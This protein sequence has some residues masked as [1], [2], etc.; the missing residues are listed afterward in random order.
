MHESPTFN[1][2]RLVTVVMLT[3]A[4]LNVQAEVSSPVGVI[5]GRQVTVTG[6]PE[7]EYVRTQ[8]RVSVTSLPTHNDL[9]N[10]L[11]SYWCYVWKIDDVE[12]ASE[13]GVGSATVIPVHPILQG[14][15][16]N[17]PSSA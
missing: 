15:Y 2:P 8:N 4:G 3:C 7:I 13:A 17:P 9:D 1:I 16:R 11:L 5:S 12:V 10:D 14:E 6:K